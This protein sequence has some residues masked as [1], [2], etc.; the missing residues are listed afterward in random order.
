MKKDLWLA[1]VMQSG[2]GLY[3]K[4]TLGREVFE[5]E[6]EAA[7]EAQR[8]YAL[9][10]LVPQLRIT[11][12]GFEDPPDGS[13]FRSITEPIHMKL[14]GGLDDNDSGWVNVWHS[15]VEA[16]F[17]SVAAAPKDLR[18]D[19]STITGMSA[20][21]AY[22]R[23]C[24]DW[25]PCPPQFIELPP[26][27][28]AMWAEIEVV[29]AQ[30]MAEGLVKKERALRWGRKVHAAAKVNGSWDRRKGYKPWKIICGGCGHLWTERAPFAKEY[31][32]RCPKC[33]AENVWEDE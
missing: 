33:G 14:T 29:A 1:L 21:L 26:E 22:C 32:R 31:S 4:G 15:V 12:M 23:E 13:T 19:L 25:A 27:E 24:R 2:K 9:T 20:Y 10:M 30:K 8:I 18:D 17:L 3:K 7:L 6:I 16:S 5:F 28:Q 11:H